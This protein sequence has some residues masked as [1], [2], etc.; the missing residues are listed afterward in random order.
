ML[1]SAAGGGLPQWNCNCP[2]CESAR[3]GEGD[4]LPR[5]QSSLAV[6]PDG[7]RWVL[8]NASPDLREQI[9]RQDDFHAINEKRGTTIEEILLTDAEIDHASGL[10]FMREADRLNL[11]TTEAV[12][13]HLAGDFNV[14][15]TLNAFTQLEWNEIVLG[16]T[17]LELDDLVIEAFPVE[18]D[19]P[20]YSSRSSS[21]DDT[22][23]LTIHD[24]QS[25]VLYLPA[26]AELTDSLMERI[27]DSDLL[28]LDGTFWSDDEMSTV[29][30]GDRRANEMGHLPVGGADGSFEQLRDFETVQ[31]LYVHIN[32]TN[33]MLDPNSP[34]RNQVEAAGF[35]V[36]RDDIILTSRED[37]TFRVSQP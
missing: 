4:V 31:K 20:S 11:R 14:L 3:R 15:S 12:R 1:G 33:P 34:E 23:G 22:I 21:P 27:A 29:D 25:E 7:E 5:T 2:N 6:S 18:G 10:L 16:E 8:I 24:G 28:L 19:P 37:G 9:N 32:N 17:V 36:A 13:N 26:L 30:E 35:R